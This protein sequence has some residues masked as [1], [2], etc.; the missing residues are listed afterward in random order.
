MREAAFRLKL[1]F[2]KKT[3][4]TAT[5]RFHMKLVMVPDIGPSLISGL[6]TTDITAVSKAALLL[7][8]ADDFSHTNVTAEKTQ[9]GGSS[10]S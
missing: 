7:Q 6:E 9:G 8:T 2:L 3:L 10:R 5:L 1:H 4:G